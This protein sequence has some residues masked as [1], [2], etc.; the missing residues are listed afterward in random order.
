MQQP[1]GLKGAA[2]CYENAH[3]IFNGAGIES[4][5]LRSLAD[6]IIA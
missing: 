1:T 4:I 6:K 5:I 2:N 3:F